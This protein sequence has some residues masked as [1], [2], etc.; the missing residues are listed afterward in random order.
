MSLDLSLAIGC[1]PSDAAVALQGTGVSGLPASGT[2]RLIVDA[3]IMRATARFGSIVS[4]TRA[5]EGTSLA[6]HAAG[7]AVAFSVTSPQNVTQT[8]LA[9]DFVQPTAGTPVSIHVDLASIAGGGGFVSI[10]GGGNYAV[11][12]VVDATHLN[13]T[14]TGAST[15]AVAGTTVSSGAVVALSGSP[16]PAGSPGPTQLSVLNAAALAATTTTGFNPGVVAYVQTLKTEFVYDPTSVLTPDNIN[17]I[18]AQG[19]GCWVSIVSLTNPGILG[20]TTTS[21]GSTIAN[22]ATDWASIAAGQSIAIYTLPVPTIGTGEQVTLFAAVSVQSNIGPLVVSGATN[23]TP[24]VLT[25]PSTANLATGSQVGV[26]G[27]AG[28]TAANGGWTITVVD[29][30]HVS[31]NGSAGN[32]AYTSGGLMSPSDFGHVKREICVRNIGGNLLV[33]AQGTTTDTDLTV[34]V[35]P[36]NMGPTL[37]GTSVTISMAGFTLSVVVTAPSGV[38]IRA[39]LLVSWDRSPIP[40]AGPPPT[41]ISSDVAHGP[42]AGGATVHLTGTSFA[43]AFLVTCNGIAASFIVVGPTQITLVTAPSVGTG[44]TGPIVVTTP[45]GSSNTNITYTYDVDPSTIFASANLKG[46]WRGSDIVAPSSVFASWP[47]A[48]GGLSTIGIGTGAPTYTAASAHATPAA[49]SVSTNGTSSN[50][51]IPSFTHGATGDGLFIWVV[52]RSLGGG[53]ANGSIAFFTSSYNVFMQ[54][55][56]TGATLKS[57][58][59]SIL[60]AWGTSIAGQTL[61]MYTYADG[62]AGAS[63]LAAVN[64]SNGTEVDATGTLGASLTSPGTFEFGGDG[65]FG[66]TA[67]E[68]FEIVVANVR[69]TGSQ[70][71]A[72]ESYAQAKYGVP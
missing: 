7:A 66:F 72:L 43:G 22:A 59:A 3:E 8:T 21:G 69:P 51:S 55:I 27:V 65:T 57:A 26:I 9:D 4:V 6:M 24:I 70:L 33:N 14:P 54:T 13:V 47:D 2:Y 56:S 29:A 52:G 61:A 15:N 67:F 48:R 64:V 35:S 31:L 34:P 5:V 38:P 10:A 44:G 36:G 71:A 62:A 12:G 63:K 39:R 28:N 20:S 42:A 53:N 25:V 1:E 49:P 17:A 45:N 41:I 11:L 46:W 16:G 32:G 19:G 37:A 18:S 60:A 58:N 23:A 50:L 40:G 30:T 68:Y